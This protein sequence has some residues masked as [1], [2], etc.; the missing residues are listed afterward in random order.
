MS[1]LLSESIRNIQ[2]FFLKRPLE[3]LPPFDKNGGE[4]RNVR[5]TLK[6]SR[7]ATA[8]SY[9]ETSIANGQKAIKAGGNK[10]YNWWSGLLDNSTSE[11][12]FLNGF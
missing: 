8:P 7:I 12:V 1:S 6:N 10:S 2:L 11:V 9:Q 3:I 4:Q 5:G